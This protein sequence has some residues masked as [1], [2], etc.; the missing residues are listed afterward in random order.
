VLL[1]QVLQVE[2]VV[3]QDLQVP[4]VQPVQ[5]VLLIQV[6]QVEQVVLQDLQEQQVLVDQA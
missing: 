4:Q 2:Q 3:L 5:L 1:I 6:L